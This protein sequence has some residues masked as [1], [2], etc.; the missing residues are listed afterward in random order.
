MNKDLISRDVL[1]KR[2][3][4][5]VFPITT[6]NLMGAADAYY[7]ILH[8]VDDLPSV[9]SFPS[10]DISANALLD[11]AV[12]E[13]NIRFRETDEAC[14]Q[15]VRDLEVYYCENRTYAVRCKHCKTVTLV[16][17]KNY[18]EA[19][20]KVGLEPSR[21]ERVGQWKYYK[22]ACGNRLQCNVCNHYIDVGN[23]RKFCP[24][25]GTRMHP[26]VLMQEESHE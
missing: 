23:D 13:R 8:I 22:T 9:K 24:N 19:A 2:M 10:F 12:S 21:F 16:Q 3:N 11:E 17:A 18:D 20:E 7:R 25:C 6:N 14:P 5:Y 4:Q 15:C 26:N 1:K